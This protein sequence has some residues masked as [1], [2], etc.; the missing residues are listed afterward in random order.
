MQFVLSFNGYKIT[1]K[2]LRKALS[3]LLSAPVTFFLHGVCQW[4]SRNLSVVMVAFARLM[5]CLSAASS[6]DAAEKPIHSNSGLQQIRLSV[7]DLFFSRRTRPTDEWRVGF[8]M[9][10]INNF[11]FSGVEV[12]FDHQQQMSPTFILRLMSFTQL[13]YSS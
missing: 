13:Y 9:F 7:A 6:V 12:M 2:T 1:K 10:C 4:C 11:I 8:K 5:I 3:A